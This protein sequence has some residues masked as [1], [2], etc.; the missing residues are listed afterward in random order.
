MKLSKSEI[1]ELL[2]KWTAQR[3]GL[4]SRNYGG[5][6]RIVK[7]GRITYTPN[8]GLKSDMQRIAQH[9]KDAKILMQFVEREPTITADFLRQAFKS[10]YI[11]RLSLNEHMRRLDYVTGQYFPTEYRAAV[12]AV[13]A[14]AIWHHIRNQDANSTGDS[15]RKEARRIFGRG[16]A[17]RWFN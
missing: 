10:A 14:S 13:L 3:S 11:G 12:C 8:Q 15:I 1:M 7:N 5:P 9:G 6:E 17:S 16:I 2:R 4:D